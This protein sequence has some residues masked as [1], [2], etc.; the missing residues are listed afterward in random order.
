MASHPVTSV[1]TPAVISPQILPPTLISQL[2][3]LE[4]RASYIVKGFITGLHQSPFHGFSVE[5]AEHR[6]YNPGESLRNLDWKVYGKTERLYVKRYAEETNLR[7]QLVV[8]C[9]DSMRYPVSDKLLVPK[10]EYALTSAAAL[11]YLMLHQ[12]DA[13]GL[14][15]YDDALRTHLP[16]RA[17]RTW[18]TQIVA[19]L[20]NELVDA[21]LFTRRTATHTLLHQLAQKM[22]RRALVVLFSDLIGAPEDLGALIAALQ[23]LRHENHEVLV[24]RLVEPATEDRLDFGN[25]PLV[26]KDLETGQQQ[27]I[28][29]QQMRAAY[30]SS[31]KQYMELLYRKCRELGIDCV[32]ADIN[33]PYERTL[34]DY[35]RKRKRMR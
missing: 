4:L 25:Q 33:Q 15:L 6:A 2:G 28:Q 7:C 31:V 21:A 19:Q 8:D 24:F 10:L 14:T 1:P 35:L 12:N 27:R 20:Q 17:R 11:G 22:G 5:F 16:A 29:P 13:V 30:Q 18:L 34:L 23:H 9:S 32:E 3:H 26:L